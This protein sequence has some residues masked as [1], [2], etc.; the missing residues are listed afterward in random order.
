MYL[1]DYKNSLTE[2]CR[3]N[4]VKTLYV[5]GSVLTGNF[6][7]ESDIDILVDIDASDP[8]VYADSYFNLKFA[9]QDLLKRPIDLLEEKAVRNPF[10][11][12]HINNS[13]QLIY[14]RQDA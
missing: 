9:L 2:F 8:L 10:L 11:R 7:G 12:E 1:D 14:A 5:F 4:R 6:N 3:Q 13:K